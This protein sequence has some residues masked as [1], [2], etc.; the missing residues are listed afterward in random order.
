MLSASALDNAGV[1]KVG[2]YVNGN[3][4]CTDYTASYACAWKLI[5]ICLRGFDVAGAR[6]ILDFRLPIFD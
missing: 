4:A 5:G 3:L 2:F 1:T 6:L